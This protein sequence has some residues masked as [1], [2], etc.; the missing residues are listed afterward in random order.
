MV[1]VDG[2]DDA[3]I[4]HEVVERYP[5]GIYFKRDYVWTMGNRVGDFVKRAW[6][7]RGDWRLFARTVPL[8]VSLVLEALPRIGPVSKDIDISYTGRA[9]H[10]R[11]ARAVEILSR[12]D[13]VRFEGGTY[14]SPDD[15]KYKLVAGPVRRLSMKLFDNAPADESDRLKKKG[16][17]AYYT[18][19]ARSKIALAL[20]GGGATPSPRYYEIAAM[21]TL[22]LSDMPEAVIPNDFVDRRHA[23]FCKPDLSDLE[24]LVRYYLRENEE[25]EAI[26][27]EGHAHLLKYHTCERRAEFFLGTCRRVL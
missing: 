13:G 15:R 10:P 6:A 11:R 9:S 14:A 2:A 17:E 18:E 27:R 23:V 25:R 12:M 16:P 4:R 7:F 21:K 19:I 26:T 3:R 1:F 24:S 22:L 20:R 5:I 8:P